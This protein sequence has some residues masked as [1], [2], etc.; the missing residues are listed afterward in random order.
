MLL[1]RLVLI[2]PFSTLWYLF[3]FFDC[4]L[5]YY[6]AS[7]WDCLLLLLGSFMLTSFLQFGRVGLPFLVTVA[8][9][10]LGFVRCFLLW[11]GVKALHELVHDVSVRQFGGLL[12]ISLLL[13]DSGL[14]LHSGLLSHFLRLHLFMTGTN[15]LCLGRRRLN[16]S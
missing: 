3:N 13:N 11:V 16:R 4:F 15:L 14:I 10:V 9:V 12:L 7:W 6:F 5:F 1:P 8:L 2:L